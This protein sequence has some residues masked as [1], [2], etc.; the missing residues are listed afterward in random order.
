[1]FPRITEES[2][3]ER[4]HGWDARLLYGSLFISISAFFSLLYLYS[5]IYQ[6]AEIGSSLVQRT[7]PV[8]QDVSVSL[9]GSF[10]VQMS[11]LLG[12]ITLGIQIIVFFYLLFA[13]SDIIAGV[14]RA[15]NF[16]RT[17]DEVKP[18]KYELLL[19]FSLVALYQIPPIAEILNRQSDII[20]VVLTYLLISST[21]VVLIQI[22]QIGFTVWLKRVRD[23]DI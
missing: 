21:F 1:M 9:F 23:Q 10:S 7:I 11:A 20:L 22:A 5:A 14:S 16:P 3:K 4:V 6:N 13:L 8:T 18:V 12:G 15:E 17:I 19:M 2:V